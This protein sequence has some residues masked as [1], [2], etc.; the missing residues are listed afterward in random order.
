MRIGKF[1]IKLLRND[2]AQS[3]VSGNSRALIVG[4]SFG[5]LNLLTNY[6]FADVILFQ[7]I[8]KITT[9]MSGVVWNFSGTDNLVLGLRLKILF[10]KK[11]SLIYKKMF[12][13]GVAVFAVNYET[14][15]VILLETS[16]YNLRDGKIEVESKLNNY[17]IFTLYS[18]TYAIFGKTDLYTC[19]D[20]FLY[21]ENLLNAINAT[22]ENLGAMGVLSPETTVGVMSKL[23][24][25][26]KEAIQKDW[27][28]NYGLK[29]GKWSIMIS[30]TPTK[31]QQI[32]LP[33]KDLELSQKLKDAIQILAGYLEVPY[34]LI[35][36]SA[37]S[38]YANRFDARDGEL[39]GMTCVSYA[40]KMFDLAKEIYFAK[41]MAINYTIET[42]NSKKESNVNDLRSTVGGLDR[43]ITLQQ[44][45]YDGV[46]DYDSA[47]NIIK[48]F[49][50]FTDQEAINLLGTIKVNPNP[51]QK[52]STTTI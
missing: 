18:D 4:N 37:N 47:K 48:Q 14:N 31:F 29:I 39:L 23:G 30:N 20:M 7:I 13:D 1:E 15:D 49:F 35:A 34:E 8:K 41:N 11:F 10:E 9:A 46:T 38:T 40:N 22:T 36:T 52:I 26:E 44:S 21:I 12:F 5:N 25:K 3:V 6:K 32:N 33:I 16:D 42:R 27:R 24:D 17:R 28:E 19:K 45:V 2:N 43:V 50:G 51:N